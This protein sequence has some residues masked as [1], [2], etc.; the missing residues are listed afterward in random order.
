MLDGVADWD[1][2]SQNSEDEVSTVVVSGLYVLG[3]LM[4]L[5]WD[6]NA[7]KQSEPNSED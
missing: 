6:T 3:E 7:S 4:N 5:Y 2:L 1:K